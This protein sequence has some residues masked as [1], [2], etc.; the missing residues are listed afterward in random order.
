MPN[1]TV[2]V[3]DSHTDRIDEVAQALSDRGMQ[4]RQVLPA[5]GMISGSAAA[6]QEQSLQAVDGVEAVEEETSFQLAPP[7][8]PVQ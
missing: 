4:V 2:T 6:D 3:S 5:I 7:D 1:V 8:S